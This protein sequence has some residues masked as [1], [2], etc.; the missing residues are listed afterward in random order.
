MSGSITVGGKI[1]ASHDNVSGKLS[2]SG[3]VDL[4]NVDMSNMV[5]P[6]GHILRNFYSIGD[7]S[8]DDAVTSLVENDP[9]LNGFVVYDGVEL[10]ITGNAGH[11]VGA[12]YRGNWQGMKNGKITV[13]GKIGNEA[14][15]WANG[16][17]AAKRFPT[18]ICGS[19][20]S[21]LGIHNHGATAIVEGNVDRC[22]GA[23]QIQGTIV[24]KG[25][26]SRIL[27]SFKK[28]GEV[29]EIELPNGEKVTG[30]FVEYSGDH[31]VKKNH[32]VSDKE[33]GKVKIGVNGRLYVAA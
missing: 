15:A 30:K 3:D 22:A 31:S 14:L 26:V 9:P 21:F 1:L 20:G 32:S 10:E 17:V 13:K 7:G 11:Y 28:I 12:A 23:D 18:L 25:K 8:G 27:P 16:S 2:M 33:T 4:A 6:A 19:A 24:V 29:K 5:F